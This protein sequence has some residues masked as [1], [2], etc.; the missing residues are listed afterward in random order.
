MAYS[1]IQLN[2]LSTVGNGG[3]IE[4]KRH[5]K[6][7]KHSL[8]SEIGEISEISKKTIDILLRSGWIKEKPINKKGIIK[9]FAVLTTKRVFAIKKVKHESC[10]II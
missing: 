2:I 4:S 7:V 8:I 10:R 3:H 1:K 9:Y 5:G 6:S